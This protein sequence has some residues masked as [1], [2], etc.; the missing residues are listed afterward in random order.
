L[1]ALVQFARQAPV[2][3]FRFGE[4]HIGPR[5]LGIAKIVSGG[6]T[7]IRA[8]GTFPHPNPFS[9]FLIAGIF[10]VL[11]LL[12]TSASLKWRL[13]YCALLLLNILGLTVTF[14]RGAYLA[15][16][17]GLIVFFGW[18]IATKRLSTNY[19]AL[20]TVLISI[21]ISFFLFKP[22]LLTRATFS[23]QSTIDRKFYDVTGV[24]MAIKNPVLGVGLGESVLHMEQYSG[25]GLLP[26]NKQPPHN[27]FILTAAELGIPAALI[28][29]W[30]FLNHLW[31]LIRELKSENNFELST[32]HLAL[33]T[34]LIC[35]LLLM[36]FDHYFYTLEQSRLLLWFVLALIAV[37]IKN[38]SEEGSLK[39]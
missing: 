17:F 39:A 19:F 14:S 35:F 8:Y 24:K 29:L 30:I 7:Y 21:A 4:Q 20:S 36:L 28:L 27:Y 34:I 33:G 38:P 31:Q 15:L 32:N 37:E 26:W 16:A 12:V 2:G 13:T 10:L 6:T 22:F 1:L 3:L 11:Y 23:D 18:L 9:A 25:Q 5:I